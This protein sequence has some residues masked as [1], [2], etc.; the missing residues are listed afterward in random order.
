MVPDDRILEFIY[1]KI[2]EGHFNSLDGGK[3]FLK[4]SDKFV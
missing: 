3:H 4:L 2:L 1:T